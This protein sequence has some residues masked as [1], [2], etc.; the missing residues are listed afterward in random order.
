[1]S[2]DQAPAAEVQPGPGPVFKYICFISFF[3]VDLEEM[4]RARDGYNA[5]LWRKRGVR[6]MRGGKEGEQEKGE[7]VTRRGDKEP[8]MGV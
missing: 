6:G 3:R 4:L 8:V 2:K 1:M 7:G 5:G